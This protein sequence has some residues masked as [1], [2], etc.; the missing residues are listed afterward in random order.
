[1][2]IHKLY[3]RLMAPTDE[4]RDLAGGADY[5]D[6]FDPTED[7]KPAPPADKRVAPAKDEAGG[8]EEEGSGADDAGDAGDAGDDAK[9]GLRGGAEDLEA[10]TDEAK[11]T[12]TPKTG[13]GKFIP[14]DRHEKLL[15]KERARR[16]EL[17]AQLAASQAGRAVARANDD[18]EKIENDLVAMEERYNELLAEG[19]TKAA[20]ALMTQ[21]RRKNT[22]LNAIASQQRDAEVMAR[23]VEKVRY[24]EALDRV[25]EAYPQ[26]NS[27]SDEFDEELFQDVVDL[28][29]AGRERGLSP[30]KALQRAVQRVM[31][32][33]TSAQKRAT[34]A[35]PRVDE[36]EVAAQRR[37]EAVKRNID[38][39]KRTPPASHRVSAGNGD[40]GK[41][42]AQAVL[43][44]S[45][46]DFAKLK[47]E[48]LARLRGDVM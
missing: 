18:M 4:G 32:A 29:Y 13:K 45:D 25:E 43:S 23:A 20:A 17:E 10:A 44:M 2:P 40:G 33:D 19:D 27:D 30:T 28:M 9:D 8:T 47:D 21:L 16:E 7:D 14:I 46:A 15:K 31:G 24:D 37:G 11:K 5:G 12:G 42:T 48:D 22:E 36:S 38:A 41:L 34:T 26:L 3:R 1:M 35:T 6:D 39:A